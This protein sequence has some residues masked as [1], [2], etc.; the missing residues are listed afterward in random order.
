MT[1]PKPDLA[2]VALGLTLLHP[3][4]VTT[5]LMVERGWRIT[6]SIPLDPKLVSFDREIFHD[7]GRALAGVLQHPELSGPLP[8]CFQ[9]TLRLLGGTAD[10][11]RL[12]ELVMQG[13]RIID[14]ERNV[15]TTARKLRKL[16]GI[17]DLPSALLN[18]NT[19]VEGTA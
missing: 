11:A 17:P 19:P 6:H 2:V 1:D 15:V 12:G 8:P 10:L 7:F 18:E 3:H 14:V 13:L 9:L 16:F 4:L 5:T